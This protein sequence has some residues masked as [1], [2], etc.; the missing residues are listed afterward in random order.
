MTRMIHGPHARS[1][2]TQVQPFLKWTNI[3][4]VGGDWNRSLIF[5]YIGNNNLPADFH[6][7]QRGGVTTNQLTLPIYS[8]SNT[9]IYGV[10]IVLLP[11]SSRQTLSSRGKCWSL[12]LWD[13]TTTYG[14]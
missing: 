12:Y 3:D 10:H 4:L 13:I 2:C 7:F 14:Q 8:L 6:I 9:A 11:T 1:G 5:P